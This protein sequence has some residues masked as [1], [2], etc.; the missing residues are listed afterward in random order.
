[1]SASRNSLSIILSFLVL[2]LPSA[3]AWSNGGYSAD[4]DNPDYGT[5]DW[6]ADMALNF[7]TKDVTFLKSTYHAKFLLGTE[8][9]DNPDYI[10][11]STYH[12]VYFSSDHVLEDDVCADRAESLYQIALGNLKSGSYEI[13]AYDIGAM[14]HYIADVGVFGHTMGAYTDW[15]SEIHHAD[16]EGEFEDRLGSLSPPSGISLAD[17]AAHTAT[18]CLA[19]D[20]T[21][22]EGAIKANIWM[23][24]NYNWAET[25][26][27]SSAMASLNRSVEAVA[28]AIN[29]LMI[30]AGSSNPPP[31]PIPD[32]TPDP[33]PPPTAPEPPQSVTALIEGS[34]IR[35]SWSPPSDNGGAVVNRYR[36]YSGTDPSNHS[37]VASVSGSVLTWVHEDPEKGVTHYYW[38]VAEN[39][40]GQSE[41][42]ET[43]SVTVPREADSML[44]PILV[45]A[46]SILVATAGALLWRSR[47]RSRG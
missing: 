26:F 9:P 21:F 27:Y 31:D 8:A 30:E 46:I 38:I 1:M 40:V 17:I 10:G 15:G 36:I 4:P 12:H 3:A 42:S 47:T 34:S 32:P 28:S 18:V 29:H 43:A 16:Y 25:A 22:G 7:Q 23:D 11:D 19:E 35:L 39:S 45:S 41:M 37:Y 6:I 24:S 20:I 14:A 13:A 44:L 5:H 33:T 2:A